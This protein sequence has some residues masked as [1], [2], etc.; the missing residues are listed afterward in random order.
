M[1]P[2]HDLVL[3]S[4]GGTHVVHGSGRMTLDSGIPTMLGRIRLGSVISDRGEL[5]NQ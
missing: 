1:R 2:R 4:G 3:V 5:L